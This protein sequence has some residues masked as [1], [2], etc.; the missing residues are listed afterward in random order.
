MINNTSRNVTASFIS[1]LYLSIV[2]G[3]APF[4][5][6]ATI[7]YSAP[8]FPELSVVKPSD[9]MS[10]PVINMHKNTMSTNA[11]YT[12]KYSS[13][14]SYA[15]AVSMFGE[16]RSLTE[17]ELDDYKKVIAKH[18]VEVNNAQNFFDLL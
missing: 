3:T 16:M 11:L 9:T 14:V 5:N 12:E 7:P 6:I 2:V 10:L 13:T 4:T 17:D 18:F 8:Q 1:G 15:N